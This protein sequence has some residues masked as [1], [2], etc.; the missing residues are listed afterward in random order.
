M[1]IKKLK[2]LV[3]IAL[4]LQILFLLIILVNAPEPHAAIKIGLERLQ[5]NYP[6]EAQ[7]FQKNADGNYLIKTAGDYFWMADSWFGFI[8][9]VTICS[10]IVNISVFILL[11]FS[12]R[13]KKEIL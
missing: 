11:L 9:A 3:C 5:T 10:M 4:V 2:I 13:N 7:H 8:V 6:T 12:L 1:K